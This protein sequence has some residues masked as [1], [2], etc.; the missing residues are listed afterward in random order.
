MGRSPFRFHLTAER[1][2]AARRAR[3]SALF[4]CHP[5]LSR[6]SASLWR[7]F[8]AAGTVERVQPRRRLR[9]RDS[10]TMAATDT[11]RD[12]LAPEKT[13]PDREKKK[14]QSDVSISPRTSKHHYSRSRSR[15]RERKR[16]S[17]NEGRKHRSRSRSKER[18]NARR[19]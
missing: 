4:L 10:E 1:S 8:G 9:G 17:D 5:G 15:S 14:E 16:K 3:A 13:S 7:S 12:G 11:E 6:Q 2:Q 19:D 18:A